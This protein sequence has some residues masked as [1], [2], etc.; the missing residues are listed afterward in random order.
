MSE[1]VG[2]KSS[3]VHRLMGIEGP[4]GFLVYVCS[5][6]LVGKVAKVAKVA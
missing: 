5:R 6:L 3:K 4:V 2:S 1:F